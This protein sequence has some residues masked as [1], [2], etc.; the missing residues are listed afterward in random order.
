MDGGDQGVAPALHWRKTTDPDLRLPRL[1]GDADFRV[2]LPDSP[3]FDALRARLDAAGARHRSVRHWVEDEVIT[4]VRP[5]GSVAELTVATAV[6]SGGRRDWGGLAADERAAAARD[7]F[8]LVWLAHEPTD[9]DAAPVPAAD[10][11]PPEWVDYLPFPTLN[12]A[13]A[14]AAPAVLG[15]DEHLVV[16]APTGAGKTVVGMLA[17][18][19]AILGDKRKAAWLVPQRSLT[20]ELDRELAAWRGRGLRVERL[21]GEHLTDVGRVRSADLWVATTEKFEAICRA[22]SLQAALAEV[23]CLVVDEVHLLGA[24]ERGPLL[25]ALLARVRGAG[26]PVRIVGLSATVSNGAEIA[27][28]LQGALVATTWRPTRLTWQLPQVPASSDRTTE[29]TLRTRAAVELVARVSGDGG[30]VLVFCGS[31][32]NVRATA[33]AIAA[34]RGADTAG[35]RADDTERLHR[36]CASVGVGLHYKDW[37]HKRESEHRFRN[38]EWD[39]LV[40]TTTVAAGV[41]LPARAV[42]VRDTRVGLDP[43]DTATV[44]QMFG[45]AGRVGAGEREGWAYLVTTE[46]ERAGWQEA[47]VG[48]YTV[49]SRI[50]EDLPD[51]VLAEAVQ[52]RLTT[53]EH[54]RRWWLGTLSHHQ[55]DSDTAPVLEAVGFLVAE[56][57][58]ARDGDRL[59][60]TELGL[61]TARLM[62]DTRTGAALRSTLAQVPPPTDP[63][64]AEDTLV[65]LVSRLVPELAQAPVAEAV[66]P[67]VAAVLKAGGRRERIAPTT[68]ATGPGA[69]TTSSPG[70]LA[71]AALLLVAHSP[72]LFTRGG[73]AVAGLPWGTLHPV[74]DQAPRYLGWLAAQGYLRAVHPWVAIVAS[75]LARRVRWRALGPPRGA[76]RLLWMCEQMAPSPHTDDVVP[77]LWEAARS[78]GVA[79]PDWPHTTPPRG[80][81]LGQDD[82]LALLRERAT[83]V[84]I[85]VSD[86]EATVSGLVSGAVVAWS[87]LKMVGASDRAVVDCP[88]G[89]TDGVAVF[90]RRGD[91]TA[92]GKLGT[93]YLGV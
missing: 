73:R 79:A 68:A 40:A 18:L 45:R 64:E 33:L 91:H 60:V 13:Q 46:L 20:D 19:R 93:H 10:L 90:T 78:R 15:G 71:R 52:G 87:G 75:D 51:H 32:P 49:R 53:V 25:E 7:A 23:G 70:D 47:L 31:K 37:E 77:R 55:G 69:G 30:S 62:V 12:P 43:I 74:L 76:G 4:T 83:G 44:L 88:P 36:V 9:D 57:F 8:E 14:H 29:N 41:N 6:S 42:V 17:A 1:P 81:L 82:Y 5:G 67:A 24:A 35:V 22:G 61:L 48:G 58:L 85:T 86:G 80:C 16:T 38:R 50:H 65:L 21:S 72:E 34:S 89:A 56:G 92:I 63:D 66:R 84:S 39:V 3:R 28:W 59:R 2:L 11:V 26:S 27:S 54:A